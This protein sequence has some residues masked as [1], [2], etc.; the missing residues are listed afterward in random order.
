MTRW[1][2]LW[3]LTL[4]LKLILSYFF[5]L[6]ADEAYYWF[7]SKHL[8]LSYFDHPP[9]I[10]YLIW[11]GNIFGIMGGYAL[12]WPAVL[13]GHF[14][15]LV[16]D[17]VFKKN[18]NT[19]QR[20]TAWLFYL[21]HPITGLGSIILTPDLPL[22]FFFSLSFFFCIRILKNQ[23]WVNYLF[24][25]VSLGLGFLSKYHIVLTVPMLLIVVHDQKAWSFLFSKK[26]FITILV[27]FILSLPVLIWN[28][29]N[30]WVSFAFQLNHGLGG[31]K[32]DIQNPLT[33]VF[34]Q[35]L[36][37]HP[38]LVWVLLVHWKKFEI[39]DKA[40]LKSSL[41]I[42][43][44]FFYSSLNSHMEAN[45]TSQALPV[46]WFVAAKYIS[47]L[48]SL[49]VTMT[50]VILVSLVGS[51]WIYPWMTWAPEKLNE[52][53][54]LQ[55]VLTNIQD[56]STIFGDTYQTASLLSYYSGK[57]V[58]KLKGVNRFDQFDLISPEAEQMTSF[59]FIGRDPSEIP[60]KFYEKFEIEK[61]EIFKNGKS[62]FLLRKKE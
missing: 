62:K 6:S 31:Q 17:S 13:I 47:Q 23:N 42:F 30:D 2:Q 25:G 4:A 27:G 55:G 10:S 36:V 46:I 1:T 21:S 43:G 59:C 7:W 22:M 29:Q 37:L 58:Y 41:F 39:I 18:L 20:L 16:W 61:K 33:Y 14:T 32:F 52:V 38:L 9:M 5:P 11:I 50:W 35:L 45:W 57:M 26:I 60:V 40:Y 15:L 3:F 12:R 49:I 53:H 28:Y 8:S 48:K 34:G 24:L 19:K 54:E 56:C 51:H 44:F